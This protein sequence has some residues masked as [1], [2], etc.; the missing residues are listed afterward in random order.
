MK[1]EAKRE[2]GGGGECTVGGSSA[3]R[4][5]RPLIF[6]EPCS[7]LASSTATP[8]GARVAHRDTLES[9]CCTASPNRASKRRCRD[10]SRD[11][12]NLP[13]I[14]R[15]FQHREPVLHGH[16]EKNFSPGWRSGGG[17]GAVRARPFQRV[18][19]CLATRLDTIPASSMLHGGELARIKPVPFTSAPV[20]RALD[21]VCRLSVRIFDSENRSD[22]RFEAPRAIEDPESRSCRLIVIDL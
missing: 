2:R 20:A 10:I 6:V 3:G 8:A 11:S 14:R 17:E 9:Y 18:A 22:S 19:F 7:V 1:E 13:W 5:A 16:D 4:C 21:G 12:L 15:R